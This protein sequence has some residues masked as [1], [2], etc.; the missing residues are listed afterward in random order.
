MTGRPGFLG[1]LLRGD[2]AEQMDKT[3]VHAPAFGEVWGTLGTPIAQGDLGWQGRGNAPQAGATADIELLG[4]GFHLAGQVDLGQFDRLSGWLSMQTSFIRVL[5]A[6]PLPTGHAAG[7][8]T[9]QGKRTIW[10][11]LCQV[12][13]VAERSTVKQV[14]P[15]API[16]PK[17]RRAVTVLTH[18]HELRGNLHIHDNGSIAEFLAA[19]EPAFVPMTELAVRWLSG[20][21]GSIGFP[22]A[23][24]N[25]DQIVTV[26]DEVDAPVVEAGLTEARSA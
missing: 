7:S 15:G 16:V 19:P 9:R 6:V 23:M 26:V 3:P 11:R 1:G 25:R 8:A 5:E 22:F 17:Q 2:P 10:V 20:K 18:A 21:G 4:D 24:I 14:R 13:A 12:V